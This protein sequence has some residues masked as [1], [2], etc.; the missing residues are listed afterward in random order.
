MTSKDLLVAVLVVAVALV[1]CKPSQDPGASG[2]TAEASGANDPPASGSPA[3]VVPGSP[4]PAM[5]GELTIWHAY[6]G[7]GVEVSAF[8][9]ALASVQAA[10]P[11]L[12][13]NVVSVPRAA[14]DAKYA[15]DVATGAGPDLLID[16]NDGL[17]SGVRNR[18][19]VSMDSAAAD[20][21]AG[22]VAAAVAGSK[23]DDALFMIPEALEVAALAY[24]S[25]KIPSPPTTIDELLAGVK[26]GSIHAGLVG[27][28]DVSQN[29][30]WWAAFG[31][32]PL[33]VT[34]KCTSD[35]GPQ[36]AQF[37]AFLVAF[38]AAQ[39]AVLTG[40]RDPTAAAARACA[41][42]NKANAP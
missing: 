27:G 30:G 6:G 26:A 2:T 32:R 31:A 7:D 22:K 24:D 33:D 37:D 19:V 40:E 23:V 15:A 1:G 18:T 10:S 39:E 21:L 12:T 38:G 16:S 42:M 4:I 25:A 20:R 5:T 13:V 41:A 36:L 17:A 34:A 35:P 28:T 8:A 11:A 3:S 9:K 29:I 14:I